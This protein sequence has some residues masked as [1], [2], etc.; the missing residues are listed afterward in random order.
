MIMKKRAMLLYIAALLLLT[1]IAF[2]ESG[3]YESQ[4]KRDPFVPLVGLDR[5]AISKLEDVTSIADVNLEGIATGAKGRLVAILNG[6]I[7]REGEKFGGI[8]IVKITKKAIT[9]RMEGNDYEKYLI[10]DGG[11]KSGR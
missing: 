8:E 1:P 10:E 6:E 5:P 2:G 7:V 9:I 11:V 4:G 3:N